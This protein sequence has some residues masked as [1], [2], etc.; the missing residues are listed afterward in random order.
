MWLYIYDMSSMEVLKH[1]HSSKNV[2]SILVIVMDP[3]PKRPL[4]SLGENI[5]LY[6]SPDTMTIRKYSFFSFERASY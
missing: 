1:T 6:S 5:A 3:V 2:T 4:L